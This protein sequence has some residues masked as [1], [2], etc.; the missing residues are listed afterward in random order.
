MTVT[1]ASGNLRPDVPGGKKVVHCMW[2]K[3]EGFYCQVMTLKP[4]SPHSI[5][6]MLW[7]NG[8]KYPAEDYK[9]ALSKFTAILLDDLGVDS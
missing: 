4:A 8:A 3:H 5:Y 2:D 6:P 7:E 1:Y 9:A